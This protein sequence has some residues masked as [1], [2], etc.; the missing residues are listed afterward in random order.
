MKPET[1]SWLK[2]AERDLK[3]AGNSFK[4]KDYYASSFWCQQSIEKGLKALLIEKT[5]NFPKIHDLLRLAQLNDSPQRIQ[6]LC[7]L[8]NPAY[9]GS[10]YPDISK[11]YTQKESK[12]ILSMCREV[13]QWIKKNLR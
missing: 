7:A 13:L 12:Q 10:R 3:T 2:R 6:E 1:K 5:G 11:T 8:V 4:S 9:T